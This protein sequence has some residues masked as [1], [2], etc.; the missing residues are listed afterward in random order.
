[1]FQL[2]NAVNAF[3]AGNY[4]FKIK[5]WAK[6]PQT[7]LTMDP[8]PANPS[9][10]F[11]ALPQTCPAVWHCKELPPFVSAQET[12]SSDTFSETG[13]KWTLN[14]AASKAQELHFKQTNK[15]TKSEQNEIKEVPW[16]D[17]SCLGTK[18][19]AH[20][21]KSTKPSSGMSLWREL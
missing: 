3:M 18:G 5:K 11:P 4:I 20:S 6:I 16:V 12:N 19:D 14:V 1:M 21:I 9:A 7:C 8:N 17:K 2:K 13:R 15:K 10:K